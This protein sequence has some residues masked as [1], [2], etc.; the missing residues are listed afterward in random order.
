MTDPLNPGNVSEPQAAN[1][2]R[3]VPKQEIVFNY[4][5][6]FNKT[7]GETFTMK[8]NATNPIGVAEKQ[9]KQAE[10]LKV[11][12]EQATIDRIAQARYKERMRFLDEMA[13]SLEAQRVGRTNTHRQWENTREYIQRKVGIGGIGASLIAYAG[14]AGF[15]ST[16]GVAVVSALATF[17]GIA[18]VIGVVAL[19][20]T[21]FVNRAKEKKYQAENDFSV[22][23]IRQAK[24][25]KT[26]DTKEN[27]YGADYIDVIQKIDTVH[28]NM[29]DNV[30]ILDQFKDSFMRT[31]TLGQHI[32]E[33]KDRLKT[34]QINK[35]M[36]D[37]NEKVLEK[38]ASRNFPTALP[39]RQ[40]AGPV[41]E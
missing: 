38:F 32:P 13:K 30:T 1:A 40:I 16:A 24:G 8:V 37:N 41:T 39:N 27:E 36:L 29:H 35:S 15:A 14:S 25:I 3:A 23:V 18:A 20:S 4:T 28:K 9:Q 12:E 19:T 17:S 22:D 7:E 10:E 11:Q 2:Q 26:Y 33:K 31:D 21:Y 6:V 5:T 34:Y